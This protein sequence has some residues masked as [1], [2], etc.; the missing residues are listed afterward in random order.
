MLAF[1]GIQ[2]EWVAPDGQIRS[3]VAII[4]RDA[5]GELA[6]VHSRMPLFLPKERWE[7]W[8]DPALQDVQKVRSLFE[9]FQPDAHLRFWTVS[10]AVNSIKNSGPDLIK[11]VEV[12]PETLF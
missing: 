2:D 10:D 11:P 3:S 5:V 6:T 9:N 4:T 12:E 1:A 7:A 8:M